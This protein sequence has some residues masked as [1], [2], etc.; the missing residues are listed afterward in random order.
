MDLDVSCCC[1]YKFARDYNIHGSLF[2]FLDHIQLDS[3]P[4]RSKSEKVSVS[5]FLMQ[6]NVAC[7]KMGYCS[8]LSCWVLDVMFLRDSQDSQDEEVWGIL[9]N[10]SLGMKEGDMLKHC[11]GRLE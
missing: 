7:K 10:V 11:S 5:T 6:C 8:C 9:T 3:S 1:P 4:M 2:T